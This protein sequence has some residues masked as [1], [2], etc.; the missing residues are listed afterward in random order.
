M[1]RLLSFVVA[2]AML[3]AA[4]P[5]TTNADIATANAEAPSIPTSGDVWDGTIEQ[6][7]KI[8]QKDGTNYYEITKCSQLAFVA[9]TGGDWLSRNYILE[10]DLIMNDVI[11][12]WDEEGKLTNDAS[13]L[14]AW[15][16]IGNSHSSFSGKFNGNQ[17]TISGIIVNSRNDYLGLFGRAQNSVIQNVTVVNS[18]IRGT[19]ESRY[20]GGIVGSASDTEITECVNS[21]RVSGC[22]KTYWGGNGVGGVVGFFDSFDSGEITWCV[23][24]GV[25][26]GKYEVGGIAGSGIGRITNCENYGQIIGYE[27][28]DSTAGKIGGIVGDSYSSVTSVKECKNNGKVVAELNNVGGIVGGG[29]GSVQSC[30]NSGT[31][32]GEKNVGGICG[33]GKTSIKSSYNTGT[34]KGSGNVGGIAGGGNG[35]YS[36]TDCYNSAEVQMTGNEGN[37]GAIVGS[38]GALWGSDT[39]SGCYYLK[40]DSI[41][42]GLFGCGNVSSEEMEPDGLSAC[43]EEE[44]KT[45]STFAGWDFGS[46]WRMN[47][48]YN[49]GYPYLA[50]E[51]ADD[52]PP[53]EGIA[54]NC[55]KLSL[56]AGDS[57][58]LAASPLPSNAEAVSL[59]WTS[60]NYNVATVNSSG[61][62]T[63][64]KAGT[65][66]ITVKGGGFSAICTVTVT[67][68]PVDEYKIGELTV[69]DS[70]G[71]AFSSIPE[72]DFI[73]TIPITKQ[74]AVGNTMV[75]LASYSESGQFKG[76][77]Y[78]TV[79]D[80]PVGATVKISLPVDN[81]EGDIA[82]LK[83][84]P[85]ASFTNLVPT[86]AMS[87]FPA[88]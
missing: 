29:E 33:A 22:G 85:I 4:V 69:R 39:V 42:A 25:V 70:N 12:E 26:T 67:A 7:T 37:C 71:E 46:T 15:T 56:T 6:P 31:I 77:L 24:Y 54:L 11:L 9:Q 73:V 63:A 75:V 52:A 51:H 38:E 82:Q 76:L 57:A 48:K 62:V 18:D 80:V 50:W 19:G 53:L 40:T 32:T 34:V 43:T 59:S 13:T 78:V 79:E 20:I 81:A 68:R 44:L 28:S 58:Y 35:T 27:Y 21:S 2:F 47:S 83:A 66:T 87:C 88:Q 61:R 41:N 45:Q 17:H 74:A 23:N 86:G 5:I 64:V 30:V 10:N 49:G 84:F 36:I 14:R 3:L 55:S 72:G 1:K 60:S 65:A 16:P 8:V